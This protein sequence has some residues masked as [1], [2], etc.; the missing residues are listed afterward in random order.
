MKLQAGSIYRSNNCGDF[1]IV[2]DE[3]KTAV[4]VRFVDTG[5]EAVFQRSHVVRGTI[6]DRMHRSVLGIG[7]RGEGP[8]SGWENNKPTGA[9][10]AWR[11]MLERC[12]SSGYQALRPTYTGCTVDPVWHNFQNFAEWYESNHK[13]G[14]HVDKDIKVDGNKVYSPKTCL[15]VSAEENNIKAHAKHYKLVSPSG[16][17]TNI[18]NMAEFARKNGLSDKNLSAVWLGKRKSHKGWT[19][20]AG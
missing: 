12:Y 5:Y 14:L 16:V 1:V 15:L 13:D 9:Y 8:F 17:I 10:I 18:Y 11:G 3:G 19:A 6:K 2:K 20:L 7:Y 4:T